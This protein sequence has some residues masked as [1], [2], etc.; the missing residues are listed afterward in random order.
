MRVYRDAALLSDDEH[1]DVIKVELAKKANKGLG[2]SI[3]GR[4]NNKGVFISEVVSFQRFIMPSYILQYF[5]CVKCGI[6]LF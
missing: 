3:V 2:L 4:R 5:C 1:F 6:V